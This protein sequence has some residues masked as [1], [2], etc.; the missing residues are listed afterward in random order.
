MKKLRV[1][2]ACM[3]LALLPAVAAQAQSVS[4]AMQSVF[5]LAAELYPDWFTNGNAAATYQDATGTYV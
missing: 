5:D 4:S 1:A 2:A 3:L